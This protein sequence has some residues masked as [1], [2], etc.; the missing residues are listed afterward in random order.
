MKDF[1]S[2]IFLIFILLYVGWSVKWMIDGASEIYGVFL[3]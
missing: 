3:Q 2:V 1:V